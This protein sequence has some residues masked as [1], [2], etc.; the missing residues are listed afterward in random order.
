MSTKINS[1]NETIAVLAA[2]QES[3][4]YDAEAGVLTWKRRAREHFNSDRGWRKSNTQCVGKEAGN[5]KGDGYREIRI[6]IGGVRFRLLEHR[7]AFAL[8]HGRWPENEVD[9]RHGKEAG[10]GIANLRE[11][12]GGQNRQNMIC[13][14][15]TG[16][17][18]VSRGKSLIKPWRARIAVDGKSHGLGDF[19][20][21]EEA[22]AAYLKAKAEL[23]TFQ[24]AIRSQS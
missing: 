5:T 2:L 20:T 17:M 13:H 1:S 8:A 14:N 23:H 6:M 15:S 4:D 19:P 10:N 3:L 18:G 7:V 21:A 22:H 9:H 24:P 11:A 12:T 16:L